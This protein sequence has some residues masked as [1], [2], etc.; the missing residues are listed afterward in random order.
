MD[1]TFIGIKLGDGSFFPIMETNKAS[2]KRLVLTTSKDDQSRA[3]LQFF[4]GKGQKLENPILLGTLEISDLS[5]RFHDI[6]VV[7]EAGVSGNIDVKAGILGGNRT[8]QIQLDPNSG[9][10]SSAINDRID[11]DLLNDDSLVA[12]GIDEFS[13]ES[14]ASSHDVGQD[15][16]GDETLGIDT[17]MDTFDTS[18][19]QD[20][21]E[22]LSLDD[23]DT[24]I[25]GISMETEEESP[26][27]ASS[28]EGSDSDS[29]ELSLNDLDFGE[30]S[31]GDELSSFEQFNSDDQSAE[32]LDR[33][34]PKKEIEDFSLD[35]LDG[36]LEDSASAETNDFGSDFDGADFGESTTSDN[37]TLEENSFETSLDTSH[38]DEQQESS[39]ENDD[40]GSASDDFSMSDFGENVGDTP[41]GEAAETV[42]FDDHISEHAESEPA[43]PAPQPA[44]S[45]EKPVKNKK[46]KQKAAPRPVAPAAPKAKADKPDHLSLILGLIVFVPLALMLIIL[47][48][49][50]MV[51]PVYRPPLGTV[52]DNKTELTMTLRSDSLPGKPF[53]HF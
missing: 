36:T 9:S 12:E 31:G 37:F 2:K 45:R 5:S 11:A 47:V 3:V 14:V 32:Q 34:S 16:F 40:F 7:L 24:G 13:M 50:N 10:S 26:I 41:F 30:D 28:L 21:D 15:E 42:H 35:D 23:L 49:L 51:R 52:N 4:R 19:D 20:E 27:P 39:L 46:E 38:S 43:T 25:D 18:L 33:P 22:S 29:E 17:G 44:T 1:S 48:V 8:E 53:D 6:E